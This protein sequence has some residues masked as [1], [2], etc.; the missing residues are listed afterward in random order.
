MKNQPQI[1]IWREELSFPDLSAFQPSIFLS[2][3]QTIAFDI[4]WTK[5]VLEKPSEA[6]ISLLFTSH[7][8]IFFV[9]K[10]IQVIWD[11]TLLRNISS[12]KNDIGRQ[13]R[14]QHSPWRVTLVVYPAPVMDRL[15][16]F[17]YSISHYGNWRQVAFKQSPSITQI[18]H[19]K[20]L[21]CAGP[22]QITP[23]RKWLSTFCT[24]WR[25]ENKI[26]HRT[27]KIGKFFSL[28]LNFK[29]QKRCGKTQITSRAPP[30]H[31]I[32]VIKVLKIR[33]V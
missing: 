32:E 12:S 11:S 6:V 9:F 30:R 18:W 31:K 24:P 28:A 19:C 13:S 1:L 29:A 21:S 14:Y 10:V 15:K 23:D 27:S 2:W 16:I 20:L 22:D 33:N 4:T 26:T 5:I 17:I 3:F 7:L 8:K 25:S